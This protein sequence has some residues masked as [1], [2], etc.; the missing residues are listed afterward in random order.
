MK[1]KLI[2]T[3]A[4]LFAVFLIIFLINLTADRPSGTAEQTKPAV[5]EQSGG[6]TGKSAASQQSGNETA[7][8][9][10]TEETAQAVQDVSGQT[11]T[12]VI[13]ESTDLTEQQD[14]DQD[15]PAPPVTA[16]VT[17]TIEIVDEES[18][19]PEQPNETAEDKW[20]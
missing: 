6:E 15:E 17:E 19:I 5:S 10:G 2:W 1:K 20:G 8:P 14:E 12:V 11:G 9:A 16:E 7:K 4:G 18:S 3:A 13:E